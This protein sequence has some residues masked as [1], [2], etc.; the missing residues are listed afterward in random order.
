MK[1]FCHLS[2][3]SK[4]AD[5]LNEMFDFVE[6]G[7]LRHAHRVAIAAAGHR[8]DVKLLAGCDVL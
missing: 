6:T 7:S 1:V 5:T 2:V 4:H 8:K 3:S